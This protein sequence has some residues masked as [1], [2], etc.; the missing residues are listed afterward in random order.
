[1]VTNP[2][3]RFLCNQ[4]YPRILLSFGGLGPKGF[5]GRAHK[6]ALGNPFIKEGLPSLYKGVTKGPMP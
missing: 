2:W 1:M 3:D 4:I 6:T 5:V